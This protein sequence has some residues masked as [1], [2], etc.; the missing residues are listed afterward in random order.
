M[1][2]FYTTPAVRQISF[3]GSMEIGKAI[4][5]RA[6]D[7]VKRIAIELG[8]HAPF[9]AFPDF[10]ARESARLAAMS[11]FRNAGQSC[12][13]A[14][15]FF[16]HEDM[17]EDFLDEA[18]AQ[19]EALV[20]GNG[21]EAGVTMGPLTEPGNLEKA[22]RLMADARGKGARVLTGGG[23]PEGLDRGYFVQPTVMTDLTPEMAIMQ[24]EPFC[25][26]LPVIPFRTFDEAVAMAND[27][28]YGLAGY[29]ATHDVT[30]AIRA[31]EALE[32]GI[33]SVGDYSPATVL[34]P[35]GGVKQS[36]LGRE[37]GREGL[38]EYVEAKYVSLV[39]R[40]QQGG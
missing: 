5:R 14:S 15:R 12:I 27:T 20:L 38:L 24:E 9:L 28:E 35:F 1:E 21:L 2:V 19:A 13:S 32:V 37:G 4:M 23:R 6:A 10:G 17:V 16:V 25:P 22:L 29:I 33:L 11:K 30:T 18:V 39:L 26:V 34:S 36:G 40:E 31:A 7:Q 8:G 3:S